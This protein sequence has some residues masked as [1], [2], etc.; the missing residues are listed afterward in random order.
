MNIIIL[1]LLFLRYK[2]PC[3]MAPKLPMHDRSGDD[4]QSGLRT[5]SLFEVTERVEEEHFI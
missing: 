2:V 1:P 4:K 3:Y 5:V